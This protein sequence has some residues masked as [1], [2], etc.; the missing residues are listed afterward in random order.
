MSQT[1]H[2]ACRAH[3]EYLFSSFPH[4]IRLLTT[5]FLFQPFQTLQNS[6]G[7]LCESFLHNLEGVKWWDWSQVSAPSPPDIMIILTLSPIPEPW[8]LS[9]GPPYQC[10]MHYWSPLWLPFARWVPTATLLPSSCPPRIHPSPLSPLLTL[11]IPHY[12]IT[13]YIHFISFYNFPPLQLYSYLP[14][15]LNP[16]FRFFGP[17]SAISLSPAPSPTI[18]HLLTLF[19]KALYSMPGPSYTPVPACPSCPHF[20]FF[21]RFMEALLHLCLFHCIYTCTY[22]KYSVEYQ[23]FDRFLGVL[24]TTRVRGIHFHLVWELD[25]QKACKYSCVSSDTCPVNKP[26]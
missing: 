8:N 2:V 14:Y 12:S 7:G 26:Q 3:G 1:S 4:Q 9:F 16:H 19:T 11:F 22:M 25:P 23:V 5:Y 13:K 24:S 18:T 6:C 20:R 10:I 21:E 17:F 15:S